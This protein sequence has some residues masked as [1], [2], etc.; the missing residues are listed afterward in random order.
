MSCEHRRKIL[1]RFHLKKVGLHFHLHLRLCLHLNMT[2]MVHIV[3]KHSSDQSLH[4]KHF[5]STS[6]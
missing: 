3:Q 2:C 5:N 1:I 4:Q 6:E